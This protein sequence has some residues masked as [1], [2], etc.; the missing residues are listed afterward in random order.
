MI[1]FKIYSFH[2]HLIITLDSKFTLVSEPGF[3]TN[4]TYM[5]PRTHD[6]ELTF[7]RNVSC[8]YIC[9]TCR[10]LHNYKLYS[11][12]A[13]FFCHIHGRILPLCCEYNTIYRKYHASFMLNGRFIVKKMMCGWCLQTANH[14][15]N[16]CWTISVEPN[17]A[18]RLE[19]VKTAT[20]QNY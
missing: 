3:L 18:T 2:M 15:Q 8:R 14:Y 12:E 5:C 13:A 20:V 11:R 4:Y 19:L 7:S 16:Q 1:S 17:G 6:I 10:D 9:S